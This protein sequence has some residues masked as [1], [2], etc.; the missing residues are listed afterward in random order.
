MKKAENRE[1]KRKQE[2]PAILVLEKTPHFLQQPVSQG[3]S[4][5]Q[6]C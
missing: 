5:L 1:K 4:I 3:G 6:A 2:I